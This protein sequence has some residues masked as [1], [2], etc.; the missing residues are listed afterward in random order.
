[1]CG[2]VGYVGRQNASEI[3]LQGLK[4]LEYRGYDSAGIALL[5]ENHTH[6]LHRIRAE[7]KLC[8]L[9]TK[10]QHYHLPPL[11]PLGIGHTRWATHGKPNEDNAHP[12]TDAQHRLA[13]IQNGIIENYR[14]LR[15][16]LQH[17]GFAFVSETDTEVIPHL[18]RLWLNRGFPFLEAVH[19][20]VNQLQGAFAIAVMSAD[21]PDQLIVARQHNPVVLGYGDEE[22]Y[23]ASDIPA[24]INYTQ[25]VLV[26]NNAEIARLTPQGVDLYTFN[27]EPVVRTPQVLTWNPVMIEKQGFRHFM[28]KEIYEQPATLRSGMEGRLTEDPHHPLQLGLSDQVW[29]T[30]QHISILAC[31]S[32]W[33]AGLV[34]RYLLEQLAGIPTTVHYASEYRYAPPPRQ[35]HTLTIGVTQSGETADTLAALGEAQQ[36][37]DYLLGITNRPESSV[38]RLVN[39]LID[40]RAGIE[41]GVAAT[42]TFTAQ[43]LAFYLFALEMAFRRRSI[44]QE[45]VEEILMDLHQLPTLVEGMLA[46]QESTIEI[47]ARQFVETQDFIYIGRGINYP[48]ALEGALKL[49]EISYIHAEG[50]PAGEMKHGPI[51]LLDPRVP[52]VAIA[53]PGPLY[54]KI[55]SNAQEAKARDAQLIG[56]VAHDDQVALEIFDKVLPV[57]RVPDLL[58]PLVTGIPLQL[59]AYHVSAIR[60]LDVDQ[61]RNLAKSVTVE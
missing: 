14:D 31:G 45:R 10:L 20:T 53:T 1:M 30:T 28:L 57:P 48:I 24:F 41:V 61:P 35:P 40:L 47:L 50:Y 37:G 15:L 18:I 22:V 55:L 27:G 44:P 38:G 17:Q 42:K 59:L 25:R 2:I 58:S 51:A 43:L 11:A 46:D 4:N 13:V 6:V 26:L 60:G 19:R 3:V 52:V 34:G 33:H 16:D 7:G 21:H 54:E 32:S 56:V 29:N 9:Q 49:K 8:N 36:R 5:E 12:H 39:E 23:F